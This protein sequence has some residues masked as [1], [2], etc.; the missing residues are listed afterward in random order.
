MRMT[1]LEDAM[2]D[3]KA[4]PASVGATQINNILNVFIWFDACPEKAD[5]LEG[6]A[7][8]LELKRFRSVAARGSWVLGD[9]EV[10]DHVEMHTAATE[11]AGLELFE[12]IASSRE[13]PRDKPLWA[14][15][16]VKVE[17]GR[18][19]GLLRV[20][21]TIG[22][23]IGLFS[24]MVPLLATNIDGSAVDTAV[25]APPQRSGGYVSSMLRRLDAL[26]SFG[27]VL[28]ASAR[29]METDLPFLD[30]Q[31]RKSLT[32]SGNRSLV[33]FPTLSLPYIKKVKEATKCTVN[34]V[35]F[36]AWAGAM[37]RYSEAHGFDFEKNPK[38]TA[39]ALLAVAVPR[40]FPED[41]DPE[42]RLINHFAFCPVQLEMAPG[43]ARERLKA[44]K[45]NLDVLKKTTLAM[46]S[47]WVTERLQP[48]LPRFL[49]QGTA[50]DV[51][52]RHS[53]VFSNVP[54]PKQDVKIFGQRVHK[55]HCA[56][57]NINTQLLAISYGDRVFLNVTADPQVAKGLDSQ[58]PKFMIQELED[59]GKS[60]GIEGSCVVED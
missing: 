60:C 44:N 1:P 59:L 15:H 26:R 20:H 7:R 47:L 13:L 30:P 55:F 57:Y 43:T 28:A 58:F 8:L 56:F 27:K 50:R 31:R 24:E 51:F 29:P 12:D 35:V 17:E 2:N 42:D 37:R 11:P 3:A 39:R 38:A 21:H 22:D 23:G 19:M 5:V 46:V 25:P 54:G 6:A 33:I 52:A 53:L 41:H 14:V 40:S 36:S 49:Q 34:D 16:I 9:G 45:A 18:S 4:F 48:L 10:E 32:Y